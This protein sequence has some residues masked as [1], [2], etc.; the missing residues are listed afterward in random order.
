MATNY[1]SEGINV[2]YTNAT[3]TDIVSGDLVVLGD[4]LNGVA[5]VDIADGSSG[6]VQIIGS[7]N[8]PKNTAVAIVQGDAVYWD[9]TA[10]EVN[11]T[12]TDR[13]LGVALEDQ[14]AAATVIE[15]KLNVGF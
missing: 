15:I 8:L 11:K 13:P 14:L 6:T 12:N 1:R 7:F 2:N 4:N 5:I 3:G 9:E 10:K